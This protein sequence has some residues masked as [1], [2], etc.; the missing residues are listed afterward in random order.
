MYIPDLCAI[1]GVPERTVRLCCY[2]SLGM[3]PKRYLLLRRMNLAW[4]ALRKADMAVTTVTDVAANFRFWNFG[5]FSVE[6][7]VLYRRVAIHD[8]A[9]AGSLELT[10]PAN[11]RWLCRNCIAHSAACW[12]E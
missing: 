1:V 10:L 2:E 12:S 6:Y 4:Q 8:A 9:R 11:T 7:K 3:G 5:R